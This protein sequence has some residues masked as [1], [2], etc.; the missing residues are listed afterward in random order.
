MRGPPVTFYEHVESKV[1]AAMR[2]ENR[3]HAEVV[4]DNVVCGTSERDKNDRWTCDKALESTMPAGSR[5]VVWT[6][7]DGGRS[8]WRRAYFGTSERIRR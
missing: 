7:C 4:I 1:T 3:Q 2:R 8:F 5:L 6:T